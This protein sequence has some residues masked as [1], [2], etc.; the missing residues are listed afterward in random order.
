MG[1]P[2]GNQLPELDEQVVGAN[3]HLSMKRNEKEKRQREEE[4]K[5][6]KPPFPLLG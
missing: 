5:K 1:F 4:R 2:L 3:S 6:M